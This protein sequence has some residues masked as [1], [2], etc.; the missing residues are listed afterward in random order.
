[1]T[2]SNKQTE[3]LV[4]NKHG[5]GHMA[6]V[7]RFPK[8]GET[9][10]AREWH[11]DEDGGK[12][13]NVAVALG[14]L[15]IRSALICKVGAD[16]GG[17]LGKKWL[18]DAGVDCSHYSL[19]EDI[20]TDVGLV[21]T[22]DDGENVVIGSP[23]HPCWTTKEELCAAIDAHPEA[24]LFITGLEID[25]RLPLEGCRYARRR[26]KAVLLNASPLLDEIREPLDYVDY[27]FVNKLEGADL[28]GASPDRKDWPAIALEAWRR[29]QPEV[30]IM[31]LGGGGCIVCKAGEAIHLPGYETQCVD[32]VAAG[33]GFLA[34]FAAGILWGLTTLEAADWANRYGAVV[35][36]R[37][38]AILS[39]PTLSEVK[40]AAAGL[41]RRRE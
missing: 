2:P 6:R 29:Y 16:A 3:A 12:G 1:M 13:T 4:F 8:P 24:R 11:F 23:A 39:Y 33:D 32:S 26:G 18:M 35:V 7:A 20:A 31:T 30:L 37:K 5:I 19:C 36:S 28:A 22:R 15:G 38:G 41:K 10:R 9:I 27:L 34:A 21:I 17:R 25:Q 14:K 40:T